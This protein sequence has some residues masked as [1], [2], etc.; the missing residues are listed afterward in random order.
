MDTAEPLID[1]EATTFSTHAR[2][3]L[4]QRD[5]VRG[6]VPVGEGPA[7]VRMTAERMADHGGSP[8]VVYR[9]GARRPEPTLGAA[10]DDPQER[11]WTDVARVHPVTTCAARPPGGPSPWR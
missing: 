10:I 5:R 4:V 2:L 6:I 7:V 3:V 9:I 1:L 11:G 8:V